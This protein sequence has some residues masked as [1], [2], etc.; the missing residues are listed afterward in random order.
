MSAQPTPGPP[1]AQA[2]HGELFGWQLQEVAEAA[3]ALWRLPG[4]V[5]AS[6]GSLP[7]DVVAV[8]ARPTR[9]DGFPR[10]GPSTSGSR[11]STRSPTARSSWEGRS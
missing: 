11:T 2:F 10:T 4:H 5:G 3:F 7:R 9:P 8:L 1:R 6:R